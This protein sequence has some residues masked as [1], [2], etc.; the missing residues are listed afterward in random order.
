MFTE[1]T[2]SAVFTEFAVV[3]SVFSVYRV[4]SVYS[5]FSVYIVCSVYRVCSVYSEH[6]EAMILA[7]AEPRWLPRWMTFD[8]EG[9]QLSLAISRHRLED[10]RLL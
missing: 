3:Y 6:S 10:V 2:V 1:F 8:I 4:C 5:I 9:F 7:S